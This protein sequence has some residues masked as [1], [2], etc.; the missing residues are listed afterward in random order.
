M[1]NYNDC[2]SYYIIKNRNEFITNPLKFLENFSYISLNFFIIILQLNTYLQGRRQ[3]FG[4]K[5][6]HSAKYYST[7]F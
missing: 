4:S 5:G 2:K 6:E 7:N 1:C 3:N